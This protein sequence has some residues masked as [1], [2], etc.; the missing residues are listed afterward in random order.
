MIAIPNQTFARWVWIDPL[1]NDIDNYGCTA[2]QGGAVD[3]ESVIPA[4]AAEGPTLRKSF[5]S[6]NGRFWHELRSI[7]HKDHGC[8]I[9]TRLACNDW[10]NA[11]WKFLFTRQIGSALF[12][13]GYDATDGIGFTF[14]TGSTT[15]FEAYS[16]DGTAPNAVHID[17]GILP[18]NNQF[19]SFEVRRDPLS[20][21]T[22][23]YIDDVLV[24]TMNAAQ[25]A[26]PIY[27][28]ADWH[29]ECTLFT[30]NVST[31]TMDICGYGMVNQA[32]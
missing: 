14:Y 28:T 29:M 27:T 8:S 13:D 6:V 15:N 2:L 31:L 25:S 12:N 17:T 16:G 21:E 4:T 30:P 23:F 26:V 1:A 10:A 7:A 24:A 32:T 19:Y 22:R 20:A 5:T 18:V 9:R 3:L 11:I